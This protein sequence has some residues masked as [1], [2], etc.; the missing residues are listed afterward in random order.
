MLL[1]NKAGGPAAAAAAVCEHFGD[2]LFG[3]TRTAL[4]DLAANFESPSAQG[5]HAYATQ[6]LV[7]HPELDGATLL[8]DAVLA[9][10]EFQAAVL[11][12][13]R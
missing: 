13:A 10:E 2:D 8:A 6:M 11:F 4:D 7:D 1:H 12:R 5:P 3:S 9:V